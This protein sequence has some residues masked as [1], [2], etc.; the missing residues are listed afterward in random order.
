MR[1]HCNTMNYERLLLIVAALIIIYQFYLINNKQTV[2]FD[3]VIGPSQAVIIHPWNRPK[4]EYEV[5][6]SA[7]FHRL[8]AIENLPPTDRNLLTLV[9]Q[10]LDPPST[11][12]VRKQAHAIFQTPQAKA[13]DNYYK[14]QVR[15]IFLQHLF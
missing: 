4:I 6:L 5:N 1:E 13:V 2:S 7:E 3:T 14:A 9:H 11:H 15:N 8:C 10:L 12:S